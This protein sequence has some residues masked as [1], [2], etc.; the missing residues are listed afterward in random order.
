MRRFFNKSEGFDAENAA[1]C[2]SAGL[3]WNSS[4]MVSMDALCLRKFWSEFVL[5][6]FHTPMHAT[7]MSSYPF[8]KLKRVNTNHPVAASN[9]YVSSQG[10]ITAIRQYY[11]CTPFQTVVTGSV[12]HVV[13]NSVGCHPPPTT[14]NEDHCDIKL[15]LKLD[16]VT[17]YGGYFAA[18]Q[19]AYLHPII[20]PNVLGSGAAGRITVQAYSVFGK[21]KISVGYFAYKTD[22]IA[23]YADEIKHIMSFIANSVAM[24][25]D[26]EL[27]VGDVVSC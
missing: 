7:L 15:K 17:L 19:E 2:L 20:P 3:E 24:V 12:E 8:Q 4:P 11:E 26:V 16:D 5:A 9:M 6:D 18:T 10:N 13:V 1:G 23:I 21:L 22:F 14:P 25:V 27:T